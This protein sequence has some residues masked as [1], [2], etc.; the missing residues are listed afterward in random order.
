M[1]SET[2]AFSALSSGV[3]GGDVDG[4]ADRTDGQPR[5]DCGDGVHFDV[6][7]LLRCTGEKPGASMRTS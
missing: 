7:V 6:H 5:V 2:S 4:F 1:V 3:F